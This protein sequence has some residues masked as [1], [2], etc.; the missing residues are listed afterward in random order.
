MDPLLLE[1]PEEL[2]TNRLLIRKYRKG[3][4]KA[5]YAL[6]ERNNNRQH[7]SPNVEEV[8]TIKNTKAAEIKVR[9]HVAEWVARKRFVLGVWLE[10][11]ALYIGEIWI[12]PNQWEVPSFEIGWFLD[13]GFQGKGF[14]TEATKR[15]LSF[16]FT[17]LRAHKVIIITRD[18]NQRSIK[19]AERLGFK[20][21]AHFREARIEKGKRYGL[22]Y[23]GLLRPEFSN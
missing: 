5:L 4:G 23:F 17:N 7:L 1:L 6:L 16:L 2:K 19:L 13:N 3:D 18:T 21:E 12:E 14:A 9:Q 11:A 15:S 10:K 20:Q 22:M 8:A